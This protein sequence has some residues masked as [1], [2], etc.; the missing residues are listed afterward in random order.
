ML[1]VER[2]PGSYRRAPPWAAVVSC[3][4]FLQVHAAGA[5]HHEPLLEGVA[6]AAHRRRLQPG[7]VRPR[8]LGQVPDAQVLHGDGHDQVS[9]DSFT[10]TYSGVVH[11]YF[12]C[13]RR[14]SAVFCQKWSFAE[15]DP[16]D[17]T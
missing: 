6:H 4:V 10:S 5:R 2:D 15:F 11:R 14:L 12:V 13:F 1:C 9:S 3:A 17:W 16:V 8:R 7:H